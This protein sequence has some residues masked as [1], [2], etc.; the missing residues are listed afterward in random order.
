MVCRKHDA[1]KSSVFENSSF[2]GSA[3]RSKQS[4]QEHVLRLGI[5]KSLMWKSISTGSIIPGAGI[6]ASKE[7]DL[8]QRL[9]ASLLSWPATVVWNRS[10][11]L[12]QLDI[13]AGS[14]Q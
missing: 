1:A 7:L 11:I 3:R 5:K 2:K 6:G 13:Q 12:D 14:L 4:Q 9:D 8:M 10:N